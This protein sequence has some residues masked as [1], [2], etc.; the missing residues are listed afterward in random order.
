[1][2]ASV[3]VVMLL[4]H[5]AFNLLLSANDQMYGTEMPLMWEVQECLRLLFSE[6]LGIPF[7]FPSIV[8]WTYV[9]IVLIYVVL[10]ASGIS[11]L[12]RN[13]E[14]FRKLVKKVWGGIR[15]FFKKLPGRFLRMD[16]IYLLSFVACT[17]TLILVTYLCNVYIMGEYAD[18]YLFFLMPII[19]VILAG[20]IY[21]ILK[22]FIK[23]RKWL[24]IVSA[25]LLIG[26]MVLNHVIAPTSYLF[27][28]FCEGPRIEELTKDA[29]VIL[30]PTNPYHLVYYSPILR[31]SASFFMVPARESMEAREKI[32]QLEETDKPV[33]LIV[34]NVSFLDE[35]YERDENLVLGED[36][37]PA[38][39]AMTCG[40]KVSQ[41]TEEYSK[42][43]WATK[44]EFIQAEW[45]FLGVLSV[46]QLR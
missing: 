28:R 25:V 38:E 27:P 46:Y 35:A 12:L 19:I 6:T 21:Q 44:C 1:M 40:Y 15:G 22:R 33:Y 30:V 8:F 23:K 45:S 14:R 11:F 32:D 36:E 3:V 17:L 37:I 18:R 24:N 7:Q 5:Q 41:L 42:I 39:E 10:F 20:G 16:K 34:S 26:V 13:E 29:H 9:E 43:S 31:E 2:A 4:W